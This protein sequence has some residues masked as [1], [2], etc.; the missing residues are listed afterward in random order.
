MLIAIRSAW[1][2]GTGRLVVGTVLPGI[3]AGY[4]PDRLGGAFLVL[5]GAVLVWVLWPHREELQTISL[6]DPAALL[7]FI[8]DRV[9]DML[10]RIYIGREIVR[11][12]HAM[13]LI[14]LVSWSVRENPLRTSD[15][16]RA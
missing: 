4:A 6:L 13:P 5:V 12:S 9:V 1:S 11:D 15:C 8:K 3:G 2:G 16:Q 10:P 7:P 14:T